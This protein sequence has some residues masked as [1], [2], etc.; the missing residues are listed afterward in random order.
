MNRWERRWYGVSAMR[1][2]A[3]NMNQHM[4]QNMKPDMKNW[5]RRIVGAEKGMV[6]MLVLILII[7]LSLLAAAANRN[8]VTDISIASN[9]LGSQQAFY[10]ADAGV[11]YGFNQL[12]Q[13]LQL[14]NPNVAAI[15]FPTLS[16]YTFGGNF[17][18]AIGARVQR[19]ATGTFA[20]LSAYVQRWRIASTATEAKT[21]SKGMV[22]LDVED[23]LIPIFQFGVFYNDNLEM[24]PGANMTFTG[25]RIHSNS[26]IYMAET[27]SSVSL[28]VNAPITSAQNLYAYRL[29]GAATNHNVYISNGQGSDPLLSIDSTAANWATQSQV[30]WN[31]NVKTSVN[32]IT[33]LNVPMPVAGQPISLVGTGQGS[34]DQMAGV[35]ITDLTAKDRNGNPITIPCYYSSSHAAANDTGCGAGNGHL[36]N[37]ITVTTVYDYR[38]GGAQ[39]VVNVELAKVLPAVQTALDNPPTSCDPGILYISSSDSSRSVRLWNGGTIP[40]EGLTIASNLPVCVQGDYNSANNPAAIAADAVTVL[41]NSWP[42]PQNSTQYGASTSISSRPASTTTVNAAFMVGNKDTSGSQYSGGLEN[43]VRFLENWSN[44]TFNYS[45]SLVCLWQSAHANSNWPGTGTVYNPPN[46][47]WSYGINVNKLPPGTPRVRYVMKLGWRVV[48]N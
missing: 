42:Q 2:T 36:A 10:A 44:V 23:Q 3:Q 9:H 16:G 11:Q 40:A 39:T 45:G 34:L 38:Q 29:D 4:E 33:A 26:N 28:T 1:K 48:T 25:G 15:T 22:T 14:L 8:V 30:I 17:I 18:Q 7:T 47:N 31:G 20:G 13:Q 5:K 19:P 46:R 6:V 21:G 37:P 32:G 27:G 41:S 35:V 24:E 43:L 12:W